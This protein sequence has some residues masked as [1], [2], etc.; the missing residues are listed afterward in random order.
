MDQ[1]SKLLK[2]KENPTTRL[3]YIDILKI[4]SCIAVIFLHVSSQDLDNYLPNTFVWQVL[5]FYDSCS[6]FAVAI[7]VMVSGALFLNQTKGEISIKKLYTKNILHLLMAYIFYTIFYAFFGFYIENHTI[8]IWEDIKMVLKNALL[9]SNY[10]LWFIPMLIG[11][12]V[13]VPILQK[14]TKNSSKNEMKY[15]LIVFFIFNILKNT[16]QPFN[17]GYLKYVNQILNRFTIDKFMG[18]IG[19]FLLG[20]Y[21]NTYE[22]KKRNRCI[23]YQIGLISIIVCIVG[24]SLYSLDLGKSTQYFYD[25]FFVTTFFVSMAIF[26]F[27]KYSISNREIK[28]LLSKVLINLSNASFGIYLIHVAVICLFCVKLNFYT[29]TINPIFTIPII[30][31]SVFILSLIGVNIVKKIPYIHQYI[32]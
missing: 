31:I 32:T 12:Y 25:H 28:G 16:I 17:F 21:L 11:V 22:I 19:Y 24:N 26:V 27:V 15:I 14:I 9:S 4:I 18:F 10:H 2:N 5:N 1:K 20:Y 6:R 8:I 13:L 3:Y 30:S 7:F 23:L 29:T